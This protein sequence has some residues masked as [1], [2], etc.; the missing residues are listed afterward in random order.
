[1]TFTT[2]FRPRGAREVKLDDIDRL[3]ALWTTFFGLEAPESKLDD[4]SRLRVALERKLDDMFR[5][6]RTPERK[7]DKRKLDDMLETAALLAL[8]LVLLGI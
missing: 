7:L 3:G 8:G 5:P 6:R 4:L 2:F 1:M